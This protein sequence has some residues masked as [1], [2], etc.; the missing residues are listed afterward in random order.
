[1]NT[2]SVFN[3]PVIGLI[4]AGELLFALGMAAAVRVISHYQ[5]P[6]QTYWLVVVG[7]AGV[8]VIAGAFIGWGNVAFLAVAFGVAGVPM[9][10][11]YFHRTLM[12]HKAAQDVRVE[13]IK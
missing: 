2:E 6:G 5:F 12:E 7:V 10:V 4:L 11:E 9:G 1:M 3:W 8:V 13:M